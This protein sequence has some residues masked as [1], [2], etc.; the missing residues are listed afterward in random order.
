NWLNLGNQDFSSEGRSQLFHRV[1]KKYVDETKTVPVSEASEKNDVTLVHGIP[2]FKDGSGRYPQFYNNDYWRRNKD[3]TKH[4]TEMTLEDFLDHLFSHK[5]DLS[6]SAIR[7]DSAPQEFYSPFGVIIKE[8]KIYDADSQDIAALGKA[9]REKIRMRL[10]SGTSE[11]I[12]ERVKNTVRSRPTGNGYNELI[13]GDNHTIGGIYFV[14]GHRGWN[15]LNYQGQSKNEIIKRLASEAKKYNVPL[16]SHSEG[17]GFSEINVGD[18]LH[19]RHG[20][21]KEKVGKGK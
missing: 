15:S 11:P 17:K 10:N 13:I 1:V 18:Y 2:Y 4:E 7:K 20:V 14:E 21:S 6:A 9:D 5:P 8:G 12:S 16:Y 3:L 19:E